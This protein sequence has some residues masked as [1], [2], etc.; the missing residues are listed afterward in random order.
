MLDVTSV[1]MGPYASQILGDLGA[2]VICIEAAG[3]DSMRFLDAGRHP[4]LGGTALNLLRN[5]RN[6]TLDLKHADG[7]AAFL[8]LAA[9]ADILLTNLRPGPRR[10]L[11]ITYD[12]IRKVRPDIIYCHAQGWATDDVRADD[13]A[14]DDVIQ[15]A[16]GMADLQFRQHGAPGLAPT[17]IGDKLAGLT[18]V[19]TV[20]AALHHRDRTGEGQSIEVPMVDTMAAFVL[21][22]HGRDAIQHPSNGPPGFARLMSKDRALLPTRD[23]YL[24]IVPVSK[25]QWA[26][27]FAA[28]GKA[29]ALD[30]PRLATFATR[31]HHAGEL[32]A[33]LLPIMIQRTNAEWTAWCRSTGMACATVVTLDELVGAL[34]LAD[35]PI[36]GA[37]RHI[38][39]PARLS[40][41]PA[42]VRRHAP[43]PG[44]Q[45]AEIL[46]E[47]G[48]TAAEI[49][50][51]KASGGLIDPADLSK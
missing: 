23:G 17:V 12:D 21:V 4:Q 42:T 27:L 8:R 39:F 10:R 11:R 16:G 2:D 40:A 13:P 45:N 51:L 36:G 46:A 47:A 19:Y 26:G 14:Y 20:L 48:L 30:D 15:A 1:I 32:Y 34:P 7:H 43:L 49:A 44:E 9:S 35:H 24:Q 29:N 38:P 5:K 41:T 50:A 25:E 6:V 33:E 37:Y 28:G 22:E 3:G 31:N 18:M